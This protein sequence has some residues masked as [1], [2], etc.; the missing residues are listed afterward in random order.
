MKGGDDSRHHFIT[1]ALRIT[2]AHSQSGRNEF[3]L[4]YQEQDI[5]NICRTWNLFL[6]RITWAN[7]HMLK[8][9]SKHVFL[10]HLWDC[11]MPISATS[12][13]TSSGLWGPLSFTVKQCSSSPHP[14][15]CEDSGFLS[16]F[17]SPAAPRFWIW[18]FNF[19]S[20]SF[21]G[22]SVHPLLPAHDVLFPSFPQSTTNTSLLCVTCFYWGFGKNKWGLNHITVKENWSRVKIHIRH[23]PPLKIHPELPGIRMFCLFVGFGHVCLLEASPTPSQLSRL[24]NPSLTCSV[25]A[26]LSPNWLFFST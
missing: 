15:Y 1:L 3:L 9:Y 26:D 21:V 18:L 19:V 14:R 2:S 10:S 12:F 6:N 20:S 23:Q 7:E 17:L 5:Q 11:V 16:P 13:P 4:D 25:A 22:F 8:K 24:Q